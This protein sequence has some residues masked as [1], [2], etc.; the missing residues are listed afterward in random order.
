MIMDNTLKVEICL[1]ILLSVCG[2]LIAWY[3][4]SKIRYWYHEGFDIVAKCSSSIDLVKVGYVS[5]SRLNYYQ[6]RNGQ[7]TWLP[8]LPV[9][10]DPFEDE[11][12]LCGAKLEVG[13]WEKCELGAG[14]KSV[15]T[16]PLVKAWCFLGLKTRFHD[17]RF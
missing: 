6:R 1:S 15:W 11:I 5:I 12:Y 9:E 4:E 13:R 3:N 2:F 14:M 17:S 8:Q 16:H 7:R 10:G